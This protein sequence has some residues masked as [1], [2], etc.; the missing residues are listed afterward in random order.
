MP[1]LFLF[2]ELSVLLVLLFHV[3]TD[4]SVRLHDVAVP[5]PFLY[6]GDRDAL[7]CHYTGECPS[8]GMEAHKVPFGLCNGLST[9]IQSNRLI[10]TYGL[11]DVL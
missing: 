7:G 9:D 4:I 10:H 5:H 6:H 11:T 8:Q 1:L 3:N 2:E